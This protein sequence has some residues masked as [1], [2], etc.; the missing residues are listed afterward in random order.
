MKISI[1]TPSYNQGR[2]IEDA[3]QS[4]L[5]QEYNNIEHIII[6]ACSSDDTVERLKKY[7]HLKWVSEPDNGQSDAL[8][9]GF[10]MATGDIIC[11]LNSDDFYL[12]G[13]FQKVVNIL[14]S[15]TIH[16]VYSNII[17]SDKEGRKISQFKS[18]IP[19]RWLSVFHHFVYSESFFFKRQ[20]L[21]DNVLIDSDFQMVMDMEF[22]AHILTRGYKLKYVNDYF[23]SFRWHDTNKSLSSPKIKE[24]TYV[25]SVKIFNRYNKLITLNPYN[26][27]SQ[28]FFNG[29][30]NGLRGFRFILK[31]MPA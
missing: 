31:L 16:G 19:V 26:K 5:K 8:N 25:E 27:L 23:A 10:K 7:P 9:K 17:F 15:S 2:F 20:I 13:A 1:I 21:D 24:I 4:V 28:L 30:T 3:I 6:D 18:H 12:P 29:I 11:W 22:V 14:S